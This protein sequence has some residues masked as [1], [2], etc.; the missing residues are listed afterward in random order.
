MIARPQAATPSVYAGIQHN[1]INTTLGGGKGV[2]QGGGVLPVVLGGS[3]EGSLQ[4]PHPDSGPPKFSLIV[5]AG[6][7]SCL[8]EV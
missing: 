4:Q 8:V 2:L 7:V 1:H 6:W 3:L 5:V